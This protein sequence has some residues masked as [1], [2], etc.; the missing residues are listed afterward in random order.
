MNRFPDMLRLVLAWLSLVSTLM[1]EIHIFETSSNFGFNNL[2]DDH[3]D[4]HGKAIGKGASMSTYDPEVYLPTPDMVRRAGYY[5]E[6]HV[7]ETKDGYFLTLHR[8]PGRIGSPVIHGK[9]SVMLQHGF[10]SSS[11]DWVIPGRGKALAYILVDRGYDVWL[12]NARGN[13]Y[14]RAHATLSISDPKF[15][16]FTWHEMGIYDLPATIDYITKYKK[17][18]SILYV[19]HSMGTTMFYVMASERPDVARKVGAMFSLAPIAFLNH[20]KSPIRIVAPYI[21]DI[22]MIARIFGANE[23]LPQSFILRFLARYGCDINVSEETI[24]ANAVFIFCGF[25]KDQFNNTLLPIVLG[26]SP[27]GTSTK[28]LL[29]FL[30]GMNSGE[31]RQYDYGKEKNL[32]I[33]HSVS[34]PAYN[35]SGINVSISLQYADNDWLASI[36]DV[37]RLYQ[38]LP[39]TIGI[40]RVNFPKFNHLDFLWGID[41]PKLV[42]DKLIFMM[43]KY[44]WKVNKK[45]IAV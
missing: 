22:E 28:T 14:S 6:S 7:V 39:K 30:Q 23:F 44:Y 18:K 21:Q 10:L 1:G 31:F 13:T 5:A 41:A 37:K 12:G 35:L 27:A 3:N 8:I 38:A 25:D 29:H 19:G 42:Y 33:Y 20:A 15:W 34:P 4:Y 11:A 9:P 43:E 17:E 24:C 36:T 45:R 16:N 26:H 2:T 32:E 40:Y